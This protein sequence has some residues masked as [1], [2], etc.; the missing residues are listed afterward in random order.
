VKVPLLQSEALMVPGIRH[1]FFTRHGGVSEGLY[2]SFNGGTGSRDVPEH[3]VENRRRM[4]RSLGVA[5]QA[6]LVPHQV[7]SADVIVATKPWS[8]DGRPRADGIVTNVKGLALGVTGADC[9]MILFADTQAGIVGACH[10]GWK[11][12]LTGILDATVAAMESLGAR[13]GQI[14][15]VLGPTIAQPSYEVG[16]EFVARF[17]DVDRDNGRFFV[18][19]KREAHALFDLPSYI[20]MR[21][22]RADVGHCENLSL[23]TY[24]NADRFFSYR[25]STH[26][27]E[28][29]YGRLV[30]AIALA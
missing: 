23:D 5:E 28:P 11:G 14:T 6:L 12:A 20:G 29:D 10:A 3:V 19:S 13:R 25:R 30:S 27:A 8:P 2:E 1:A 26:L 22:Q 7:H 15:A 18:S 16:P 9:G 24:A 4:A 17:T 21:L